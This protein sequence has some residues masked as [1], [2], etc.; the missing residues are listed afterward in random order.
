[1]NAQ[2][3]GEDN[4]IGRL[5]RLV[6]GRA[7]VIAGI[8]DDCAVVRT[9]RHDPHDLLLKSDPVIESVHFLP[10]AKGAAIGHKALGRVLSDVAAMGGE[11][12]W[13][14]VDLVVP[15]LAPVARIEAL[16]RGM[17]KL[18]RRYGVAIVG[19][20]TSRGQVLEVHLFAVGRVRRGTA[21]L[22]SGASAGDRLYV[23]GVLGGSRLGHHL[24]F[25]PR[26][27]EGQW[28]RAS[29]VVTAMMDVSDGLAT[30]LRRLAAASGVGA[31]LDIP[32]IPVAPAA[33]R[34]K[35]GRSAVEHALVDGED[36]EL[37][38]TVPQRKTAGFERAWTRAFRLP[39]TGIG[40]VT[41]KRGKVEWRD[42]QKGGELTLHGYEHFNH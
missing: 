22:R 18:A 28:L 2:R 37:L 7:D 16:Y 30:D 24:R 14:L 38:F 31:L 1:M 42:G 5:K 40:E 13:V 20:D 23:T 35:E 27:A 17:A 36:F 33:R 9:G 29:G 39:C 34:L 10:D 8:G 6:P 11:P 25:E 4:L 3:I 15:P 21:I 19:G 41:A 32:R 26:L 12:L